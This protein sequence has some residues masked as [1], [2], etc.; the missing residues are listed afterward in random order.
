MLRVL[1]G[2]V[3][4]LCPVL[5]L[6]KRVVVTR[7][8]DVVDVLERQA[9]FSVVAVY[10]DKMRETSG[11]F[12]L[13]MDDGEVYRREAGIMRAVMRREDL[14][15][16]RE[17]VRARAERCVSAARQRGEIDAVAELTRHVPLAL[18]D[19]YFGV[20]GPTVSDLARWLRTIF[21]HLFL[22]QGNEAAV[23]DPALA[24]AREM[25][26]YLDTLIAERRAE[27]AAGS[28]PPR[29]D[30]LTRLI[31]RQSSH[32]DACLDDPGIRR[33]ISGLII[34][35]VDTTS[36]AAILALGVLLDRPPA[37]R[38]ARHAAVADE[39]E[40]L[41]AYVYEALRFDPFNPIMFRRCVAETTIGPRGKVIKAGADVYL[42]PLAAMFDARAFPAPKE[43]RTDRMISAYLH[44]GFALHTC[45]GN[46]INRVTLPEIL[47]PLLLDP[48]L[49]RAAGKAGQVVMDGP[50][51]DKLMLALG[52]RP[53]E[54][55]AA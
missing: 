39:Q 26:A 12:F 33:N 37:L 40:K 44:F 11:D 46:F 38:G 52:R 29:D 53:H 3:R 45:Y 51:P 18:V 20:P 14:E 30:L 43:F 54:E 24:S 15:T 42:A 23:R 36:K 50:F 13:G 22:N 48:D 34:G 17:M 6:G 19:E 5:R 16:I 2:I 8:A 49:R 41:L 7:H 31:R 55:R 27:L 1:L 25:N 9:E 32:P 47:R 10:A 35:A 28:G 21:H 4:W